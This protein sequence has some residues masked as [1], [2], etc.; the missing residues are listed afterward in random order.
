VCVDAG[1]SFIYYAVGHRHEVNLVISSV[2]GSNVVH[3]QITNKEP[4]VHYSRCI[5]QVRLLSI[6]KKIIAVI[7]SRTGVQIFDAETSRAL[8]Y[9]PIADAKIAEK[10]ETY[11][12]GICCVDDCMIL[13]GT[14]AGH[15]LNFLVPDK[16]TK[17][18]KVHL[19]ATITDVHK[20]AIW[21]IE[22]DGTRVASSDETGKI[23]V[24]QLVGTLLDVQRVIPGNMSPCTCLALWKNLVVGGFANGQL[25]V[26]NATEGYLAAQVA[27]HAR[28]ITALHVAKNTGHLLSASEDTFVQVWQL[29]T[30]SPEIKHYEAVPVRDVQLQGACFVDD[31]GRAFGCTGYDQTDITFFSCVG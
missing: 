26:F 1:Q 8:F 11:G 18:Q 4:A 28:W 30:E 31:D 16:G 9:H 23:V 20:E 2:D 22:S 5:M 13:V 3:K 6:A 17:L 27:A 15:I 25:C 14:H 29:F 21:A 7:T 12:R 10:A 24:W 19:A